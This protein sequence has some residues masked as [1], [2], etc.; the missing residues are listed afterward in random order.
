[1]KFQKRSKN[2][3]SKSD[4]NTIYMK[5]NNE[6]NYNGNKLSQYQLNE[7]K[8]YLKNKIN[9]PSIGE[10]NNLVIN[11]NDLIHP[12]KQYIYESASKVSNNNFS[13]KNILN[14]EKN[15]RYMNNKYYT[16]Y[17]NEKEE[18]YYKELQ[19]KIYKKVID[20]FYN[21][22]HKYCLK[23]VLNDVSTL[24]LSGVFTSG[25]LHLI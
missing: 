19:S 14:N 8:T 7:G 15:L 18:I 20:Q 23:L 10:K 9:S 11:N 21:R 17:N 22:V 3:Y 6:E 2:F 5:Q 12:D 13:F 4:I 1:M 24:K 25:M 16:D